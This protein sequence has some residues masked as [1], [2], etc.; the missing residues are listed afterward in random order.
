M[1]AEQ[2]TPE[3]RVLRGLANACLAIQGQ[4][5]N[6]GVA[7]EDH[8]QPPSGM[9]TCKGRVAYAVLGNLL[10]FHERHPE[11]TVQLENGNGGAGDACD[12]KIAAVYA[13]AD[14]KA[15][16]GDRI[17]VELHGV[18]FD[19]WELFP[20]GHVTIAGEQDSIGTSGNEHSGDQMSVY[21]VVPSLDT[22][23]YPQTAD[24][25][26]EYGQT[27]TMEDAFTIVAPDS[28]GSVTPSGGA[29]RSVDS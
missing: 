28:T 16:P 15:K 11:E 25:S 22:D 13:G 24:V 29:R 9:S 21:V 18:F 6:W 23:Q 2:L 4:G 3:W 10:Q 7:A 14:G 20:G 17:K 26:I 12:F 19:Y 8:A 1:E 5:G 27:A